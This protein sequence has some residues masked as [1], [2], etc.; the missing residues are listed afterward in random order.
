MDMFKSIVYKK[1][2]EE[3][4]IDEQ[5]LMKIKRKKDSHVSQCE[6]REREINSQIKEYYLP[7]STHMHIL[8]LEHD[9]S[10]PGSKL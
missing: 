2:K 5:K 3:G 9:I 1:R 8:I 10:L 4:K 6:V 7:F